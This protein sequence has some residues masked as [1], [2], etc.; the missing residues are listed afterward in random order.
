MLKQHIWKPLF[1]PWPLQPGIFSL[2]LYL[3]NQ[4]HSELVWKMELYHTYAKVAVALASTLLA[5]VFQENW[6]QPRTFTIWPQS[7][8]P[9]APSYTPI[10]IRHR[11]MKW[12]SKT[13][14]AFS[15]LLSSFTCYFYSL[16]DLVYHSVLP[17]LLI[18]HWAICWLAW[19]EV[20]SDFNA[21]LQTFWNQ[22]SNY[23]YLDP[24]ACL[25][26][27]CASGP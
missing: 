24:S 6:W 14:C 17:C 4:A 7:V 16:E 21:L 22:S 26:W 27:L 25:A 23:S 15:C 12:L 3:G 13:R 20:D 18:N 19:V 9:D 5:D 2:D 8:F 11:L 10:H 1:S